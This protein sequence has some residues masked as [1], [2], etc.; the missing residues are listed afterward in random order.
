MFNSTRLLYRFIKC[1]LVLLALGC[2][3]YAQELYPVVLKNEDWHG[4]K[5][6]L[7]Y[8]P[9]GEGFVITNG[10]RRFNRALY[11][12]PTA[13]R[14]EAGDLPEFSLY[15]PGLGGTLKLGLVKGNKSIWL[16][17]AQ[18]VTAR[19]TPGRMSYEIHDP[20]LGKGKLHISVLAMADAEGMVLKAWYEGS[21]KGITLV[22]AFGGA[23]GKKFSRSGDMGPDP[24]S[25]FYLSA[26]NCV[27]N[28]YTIIDRSF[29]LKY[30]SGTAGTLRGVFP[31]ALKLADAGQLNSP[32]K[33]YQSSVS[34]SPVLT[35]SKI[36][37]TG[38][39]LY[40]AIR[41]PKDQLKEMDYSSL[42]A[43]FNEAEET[44]K[45]IAGRVKIITPDPYINTLGGAISIAED[46]IWEEPSYMHGA[47]GWRIR[48]NGWRGP[49]VA[50]P[51]GLHERAAKHFEAYRKSQVIEPLSGPVVPDTA[52]HL[53]RH[54]EKSGTQLFSSGYISRDPD[55][56][57]IRPHHYDMNLVYIDALLWHFNWKAGG[58]SA[59][60]FWPMLKRHLDWEK[61]NFDP[62]ND[63]LYDAYAA[64][65][66]SDALYYSGGAVTHSSAYNYRA[67][68]KAAEIASL[69]G[70]DPQP[71]L[72]ESSKILKAMN[73]TL[74]MADKGTYAEYKDGLGLKKLHP[75]AALWTVYH[76][77][78]AE[79]PDR[80]QS[81]Q[82][83]RY[84]DQEIPHI[85]IRAAGL[86]A[87]QYYTLS[88]SNWMPYNWSVNNV[89]MAESV[90]T[91]LANWE[92]G[93]NEEG[94]KLFKS[95]IL[96]AMYLGGSPANFVQISHYD[97]VRGEA[98]RDFADPIG[99]SARALVEGLFG[100]IPDA[101]HGRLTVRPG[102][103][104]G[105]DHAAIVTP[106]IDFSFKRSPEMDRYRFKLFFGNKL[107]LKMEV[108]ARG[109][110]LSAVSINGK[111]VNWKIIQDAVGAPMIEIDT[112][113]QPE[114]Y[115]YNWDI[116]IIWK[117]KP[118][119]APKL[120]NI[121]ATGDKLN[122]D[123][124]HAT[125]LK[126]NDPQHVF[127]EFK[128]NG[129]SFNGIL[130]DH[131]GNRTAFVQLKMGSYTWWH[132][133]C[134]ELRPR[135]SIVANAKQERNQLSFKLI[136]NSNQP[137][138]GELSLKE[139][140][141]WMSLQP[142][143]SSDL[144]T[145]SGD[146]IAAGTNKLDFLAENGNLT[147]L[148]IINWNIN[149]P[150]IRQRTIDLNPYFNDRVTQIF[151]NKYLS[152]RPVAGPTLQIPWQGIGDWPHALEMAG[153]EDS[154]LR[155]LA[156]VGNEFSLSQGIKL[157][158]P[159]EPGKRNI[160]FTSQWDNYPSEK[161][162]PLSG[163]AE[164][165]YF[166]MAGSTNH[167]QSQFDNGKITITYTDG[168]FDELVL[169]NPE[170]WWPIQKDYDTDGFAFKLNKPRPLRIHLKTGL[171]MSDMETGDQMI[172][173]GA[174]TVLD[175]PLNPNK[176]LKS[177]KL[178][179]LANDVIIGLMSV[180][181]IEPADKSANTL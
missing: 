21:E 69:I 145:I 114:T 129:T 65:W 94:F 143:D 152:P 3:A 84:V 40:F 154:G 74:W 169:R 46:A 171:V 127:T 125:V 37:K 158:T 162:I 155:K 80:F 48:L 78:D 164:H 157:S 175:L 24:E 104:A 15:M 97:A 7:R 132:P 17:D 62:D 55:G 59:K 133:I 95:E 138:K 101:L 51:L 86:P 172:E 19:Y 123:F 54:Q 30:G 11:G 27:T 98:Y 137:V 156:G 2:A 159:A 76:S 52:F 50:D 181:L 53:A 146:F 20:V 173:G 81:W 1:I 10:K 63:G 116:H 16:I 113:G 178:S 49:Y 41:N 151:K 149:N 166:M 34:S 29:T 180:T 165:A 71:Y 117:G 35:G 120:R 58:A 44:R 142:G 70:E 100:I 64:I 177:L 61:R 8:H 57:S 141:K 106:D 28:Q 121:Y 148:E 22:Y 42:S 72:A 168:S 18:K 36:L 60:H 111:Q 103:P 88:T 47:V 79:V 176:T 139:F 33:L 31:S 4:E 124:M 110:G 66:A 56:K 13:F 170:T 131:I 87:G 25:S 119:K 122:I 75:S 73:S 105:W 118:F 77:I 26:E 130:G 150:S 153:I 109:S 163:R 68:K 43:H 126:L 12:T 147:A 167:M 140:R 160:L 67:N 144:V 39:R 174:A 161:E 14:V 85:P 93:R 45:M 115:N 99:V 112:K 92:A 108:K 96:A 32:A 91:A 102:F 82:S 9:D 136:N 107:E 83:L 128:W 5:R 38:E 23:S 179:T 6:E 90:H 135:V 134:L 89:V